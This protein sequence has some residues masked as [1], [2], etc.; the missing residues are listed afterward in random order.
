ML[1]RG[2]ELANPEQNWQTPDGKRRRGHK[3]EAA[4][5]G[6]LIR[7]HLFNEQKKFA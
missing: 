5:Q 6:R 1:L 2:A 7:T 3:N 4:R